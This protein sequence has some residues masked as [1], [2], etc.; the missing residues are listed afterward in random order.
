MAGCQK[1]LTNLNYESGLYWQR[2]FVSLSKDNP[3]ARA[4]NV[5]MAAS[6]AEGILKRSF[7]NENH[8]T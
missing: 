3:F 1:L 6:F 8:C 5:K 4:H 2:G 7:L